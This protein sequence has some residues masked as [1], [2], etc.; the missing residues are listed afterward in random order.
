MSGAASHPLDS[1][2][3]PGLNDLDQQTPSRVR[4]LVSC[5][6]DRTLVARRSGPDRIDLVKIF[7]T[8][9]LEDAQREFAL[10]NQLMGE[11]LAKPREAGV[12]PETGRPCLVLDYLVGEN[13]AELVTR[14]GALPPP[15]A[16]RVVAEVARIVSELH[17]RCGH[18]HRDLKPS[19]LLVAGTP[20]DPE[21][22]KIWLLDFEHVVSLRRNPKSRQARTFTGG[23]HGYSPP[24]AY[25]GATPTAS[26]DVFA[27]G[28]LLWFALTGEPAHMGRDSLE[29]AKAVREGRRRRRCLAG[30]PAQLVAWIDRCLSHDPG[31]RPSARE[32]ADAL[33]A[34]SEPRELDEAW[35]GIRSAELD[36]AEARLASAGPSKRRD[37]LQLLL[38]Q[39][40]K[41]LS[42]VRVPANTLDSRSPFET[43]AARVTASV[44]GVAAFLVRFPQHRPVL[45]QRMRL[46]REAARLI[47]DL[48]YFVVEKKRAARHHEAER[49]IVAV[50]QA[51]LATTR[52]PGAAPLVVEDTNDPLPTPRLRDPLRFL[53]L[54][55][56]DVRGE[57]AEHERLLKRLHDREAALDLVGVEATIHEM[58]DLRTGA[59][60]VVAALKDRTHRLGFYLERL[61]LA[62]DALT[63][64]DDH[65]ASE[66]IKVDLGAATGLRALCAS[67]IGLDGARASRGSGNAR[68]VL[69]SLHDLMAEFPDTV[70]TVQPAA[71]ALVLALS[72]LTDA[73][74]AKLRDAE[75]K[76]KAVPI[77]IRPLQSL[78]HAVD[79]LRLADLLIDRPNGTLTELLD[80]L[81]RLRLQV[82]QARAARDRI[83]R[84]AQDSL[85][86]GHITTAL[87]DMQRAADRFA[88]DGEDS[89]QGAMTLADSLEE[90]R[91]RRKDFDAAAARNL[92]L[93]AR[94]AS[95]QDDPRS[96]REE[97]I[98]ALERRREALLFLLEN[99]PIERA[100]AW[101]QDLRE[102]QVS[103]L[104]ERS[105]QADQELERTDD[106]DERLRIC[107]LMLEQLEQA[108][109]APGLGATLGRVQRL[110]GR[111]G[112]HRE[113]VRSDL[114][115]RSA[116]RRRGNLLR[117]VKAVILVG[118]LLGVFEV[119]RGMQR[120]DTRSQALEGLERATDSALAVPPCE[121]LGAS[122]EALADIREGRAE[123]TDIAVW[124]NGL[125][126]EDAQRI[127]VTLNRLAKR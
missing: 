122:A 84:S 5:S 69:R 55:L 14:R 36:Q 127:R 106:L 114:D 37:S 34:Y 79:G 23:S 124:L 70:T 89:G 21:H 38:I 88:S 86:R 54:L 12:D 87:F 85:D 22:G 66:G 103:L 6:T 16:A 109:S 82:E 96:S 83:T 13:L 30:A 76:L 42:K 49:A 65:L 80:G 126:P 11:S 105:D 59:S 72:A 45:A 57:R 15:V 33:A 26:F 118:L 56:E 19:N 120:S 121:A 95:L 74:W 97:R 101:Q 40:Q 43:R 67:R 90:A 39:R 113:R 123:S 107:A 4:W 52:F 20:V 2:P 7:E 28:A 60:E 32:L 93:A 98:D 53:V 10:A 102:A 35:H 117:L 25:A 92:A 64:L 81:E 100:G 104:Q 94:Y 17:E 115:H 1:S 71:Q 63:Q 58:Q 75:Q 8:G 99:G 18:A 119:A 110:V 48:P 78:V 112:Q 108:T 27:L 116:L 61:A 73:S 31:G 51:L 24:E 125:K 50:H 62:E 68:S 111:W 3:D 44:P 41:L 91:R 9:T 29:V 46:R 47:H 77:P